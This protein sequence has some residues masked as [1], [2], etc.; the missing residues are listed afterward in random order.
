MNEEGRESLEK[1]YRQL[2][3]QP[4]E[5]RPD[6]L[7]NPD[8]TYD[9]AVRN[10]YRQA[11]KHRERLVEFYIKYVSCFAIIVLFLAVAQ[12]VYRVMSGDKGFEIM[13]QWTLNILITG[14]FGN[15]IG[16]LKIVTVNVWNFKPFF[17]HHN[18]M[19]SER[20]DDSERL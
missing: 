11:H 15:F 16:L 20:G 17:D 2:G 5:L 12:A 9:K 8:P 7:A 19:R 13:P 18:E 6:E 14:M 3:S 1:L 4:D 10:I